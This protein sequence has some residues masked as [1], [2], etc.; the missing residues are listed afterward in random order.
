LIVVM[1]GLIADIGGTNARFALVEGDGTTR[2]TRVL[3]CSEYPT[4]ED[5]CAT[6]LAEVA[7]GERP[8]RA[9]FAVASP[10]IGDWVD[11]TNHI[12]SFSIEAL[13]QHLG[14][15]TLRVVNDFVA[16]ALAI[17]ALRADDL[18]QVGGRR[19]DPGAVV[20]ILGPGTG[21]GVA[22]L[23][24]SDGRWLPLA[25]EGGH[26]TMPAAD[27]REAALLAALRRR[28]G[29]VSAER[30]VSGPGLVNLYQAIA[31][32][33]GRTADS[34]LTPPDCT[35]RALA[36][37]CPICVEA[38]DVFTA[39]L[40]VVAGNLTLTLGA[41]G[42]VYIAGGIVPRLGDMFAASRFRPRFEDKGRF[43]EYVAPIPA[44]VVTHSYPAFVGL[45]GLVSDG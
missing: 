12:W 32:V 23:V 3:A 28:F 18:E 25:T 14:F 1:T 38:L 9:A 45:A 15:E 8:A 44:F 39:M 6:Y 30:V 11:M 2:D 16:V 29:H 10:V 27:D 24:P 26:V 7:P 42:G 19:P 34:A 40:G 13:H 17:P 4:L 35:T 33:D 20:A 36:R 43:R 5:A 41:R 22:G 37:S 21:L 31:E